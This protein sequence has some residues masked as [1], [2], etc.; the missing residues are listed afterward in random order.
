MVSTRLS[1]TATVI[2]SAIAIAAIGA[3][4]Y[5]GFKKISTQ[6]GCVKDLRNR[7]VCLDNGGKVLFGK[8]T[9]L[10]EKED[11]CQ[12]YA[13]IRVQPLTEPIASGKPKYKLTF[14]PY[15]SVCATAACR[16]YPGGLDHERAVSVVIPKCE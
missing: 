4:A 13:R 10:K 12:R 16:T 1:K 7:A 5:F 3:Y 15:S 9:R 14:E 2:G 11:V 8:N 6:D